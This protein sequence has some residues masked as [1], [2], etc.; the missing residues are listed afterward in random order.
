MNSYCDTVDGLP[1]FRPP[2]LLERLILYINTF[3]FYGRDCIDKFA[4]AFALL[5]LLWQRLYR[6][7]AVGDLITTMITTLMT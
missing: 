3:L 1:S 4:F 5:L 7:L 2:C 6:T